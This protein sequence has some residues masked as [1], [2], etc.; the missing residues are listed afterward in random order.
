MSFP[1]PLV[2]KALFETY[3]NIRKGDWGLLD[4]ESKIIIPDNANTIGKIKTCLNLLDS[5]D[6]VYDNVTSWL[7]FV[8]E[9][10]EVQQ[11]ELAI[12]NLATWTGFSAKELAKVLGAINSYIVASLTDESDFQA[13]IAGIQKQQSELQADINLKVGD[14]T[15]KQLELNN[16]NAKWVLYRNN[17]LHEPYFYSSIKNEGCSVTLKE[18]SFTDYVNNVENKSRNL[19]LTTKLREAYNKLLE[20]TAQKEKV[21]TPSSS[22]TS[23]LRK[24][25][26]FKEKSQKIPDTSETQSHQITRRRPRSRVNDNG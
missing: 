23:N 11:S 22:T 12:R 21:E 26:V 7:K 19:V 25:S 14:V 2:I 4:Q 20:E 15:K 18:G 6:N 5:L 9:V 17:E 8:E 10:A 13:T 1:N 24:Q 3:F 16:L